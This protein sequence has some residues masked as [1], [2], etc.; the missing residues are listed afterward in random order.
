MENTIFKTYFH[1]K[2]QD[3]VTNIDPPGCPN[4]DCPVVCGTPGSMVHFY[5]V[6]RYR[7]FNS[8]VN[9][10]NEII[11]TDSTQYKLVERAVLAAGTSSSS[12]PNRQRRTQ[13][14]RFMRF[15]RPD[16]QD[17]E[18]Q[19]QRKTTQLSAD[20]QQDNNQLD[21]RDTDPKIKELRTYLRSFRQVL[22]TV[23]GGSVTGKTNNLPDC[24]WEQSFKEYILSFP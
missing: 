2:C 18:E 1:G 14:R 10:W 9:L 11:D 19:S 7:A 6:F 17:F 21:K 3:P 16:W 22:T 12:T 24:S 5:P 20:D 4:P 23:C 8:T 15:A 13:L